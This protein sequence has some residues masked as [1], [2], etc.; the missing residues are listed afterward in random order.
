VAT[1]LEAF[2]EEIVFI[3]F[4]RSQFHSSNSTC[5][6]EER[7]FS[8]LVFSIV[9]KSGLAKPWHTNSVSKSRIVVLSSMLRGALR[10]LRSRS[11]SSWWLKQGGRRGR[12]RDWREEVAREDTFVIW[13]LKSSSFLMSLSFSMFGK[14][15]TGEMTREDSVGIWSVRLSSSRVMSLSAIWMLV[16]M[17]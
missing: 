17:A 3:R 9:K 13:S 8:E 5:N 2:L 16:L 1:A 10:C 15:W 7:A 4:Q 11:S 12:C 14:D 6:R